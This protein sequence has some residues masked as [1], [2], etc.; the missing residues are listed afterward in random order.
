MTMRLRLIMTN[1]EAQAERRYRFSE[2]IGIL[3]GT[4]D[5]TREQTELAS[6]EADEAVK[7]LLD[8]RET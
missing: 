4:A 8:S 1:E 3:C 2:R 5:P 6:K 7:V